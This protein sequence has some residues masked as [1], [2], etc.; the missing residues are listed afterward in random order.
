MMIGIRV[1]QPPNHPLILR[2]V[3]LRLGLKEFNTALAQ[4]DGDL[5][6][7]VLKHKIPGVGQEVSDDLRVSEGF[8]CVLDFRAHRFVCLSANSLHRICESHLHDR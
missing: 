4:C 8:V 6:P 2:I 5:D 3:S 1:E 7:F